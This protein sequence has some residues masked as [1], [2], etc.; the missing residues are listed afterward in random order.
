VVVS[1]GLQI[2][3]GAAPLVAEAPPPVA[4]EPVPEPEP[5]EHTFE[6][7]ADALFGFDSAELTTVGQ[8]RIDE[9]VKTIR[10]TG[11]RAT[12]VEITGHTDPL[13][14]E[15]YNQSLS[16]QRAISVRDYLLSLDIP[17]TVALYTKG[18][19]ESQLKV[20]EADCRAQ[21]MAGTSAALIDCLAPNRRVEAIVT[22]TQVR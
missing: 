17:A 15:A 2:P 3:F 22:G 10:G 16:E 9:I 21:G 14:S 1:V 19:G 18:L 12:A 13:G 20:T 6:L 5:V 7:S 8:N 11:F 4:P